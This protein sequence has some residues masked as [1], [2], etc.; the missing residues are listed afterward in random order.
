MTKSIELVFWAVPKKENRIMEKKLYSY[1]EVFNASV[2]Y[3]NGD[4]LAA[5]V[6]VDKYEVR[7]YNCYLSYENRLN[8]YLFNN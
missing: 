7:I 5:K 3:F 6:F 2:E 1:D 8:I 4:E